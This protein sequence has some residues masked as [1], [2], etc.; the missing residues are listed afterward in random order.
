MA[1]MVEKV[2][3]RCE[4]PFQILAVQ[5]RRGR[6]RYCSKY[7]QLS[8]ASLSK[9]AALRESRYDF[10]RRVDNSS[11]ADGCWPWTGYKTAAGYGRVVMHG[12]YTGAHRVALELT[13]GKNPPDKPFA[14]HSC[15]N[16][17]CCN[18]AHL[19]WATHQDNVDDKV[20]RGR[21]RSSPRKIDYLVA[22]K[23]RSEG[24]SYRQIADVFGVN[25]SSVARALLRAIQE[26]ADG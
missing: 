2:C 1:D 20:K 5:A 17:E 14:C 13:I 11:G 15:D 10:W 7:C 26:K 22:A 24:S 23:M 25:Q 4:A 9:H 16:P 8:G 21:A 12:K 18:P 19:R 3:Q 6:G